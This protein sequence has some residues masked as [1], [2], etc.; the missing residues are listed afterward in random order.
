MPDLDFSRFLNVP[1]LLMIKSGNL[2]SSLDTQITNFS[3]ATDSAIIS[4]SHGTIT[5]FEATVQESPEFITITE[6]DRWSLS[7][8]LTN[9]R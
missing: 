3:V 8:F 9:P 2:V 6:A 7:I 4:H 1:V 5:I